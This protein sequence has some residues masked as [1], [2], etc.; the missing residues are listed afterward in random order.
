MAKPRKLAGSGN[1]AE[2]GD[3]AESRNMAEQGFHLI[4]RLRALTTELHALERD[5]KSGGVSDPATLHD[6]R[7]AIDEVRMTAWTASEL[8]N[9]RT[10]RQATIAS[11]LAAE[12]IRRFAQMI[13]DFS[14]DLE[15]Q[16]LTWES[17]GVQSLFDSVAALQSHL[18][19][20]IREHRAA[21]RN[22]KDEQG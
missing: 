6:F 15:H 9:A 11:F 5:L 3:R 22:L 18:E 10:E 7:H 2:S 21:F 16:D 4:S 12:R 1:M 19:R 13:R 20:L 14:V 8:H 17:G